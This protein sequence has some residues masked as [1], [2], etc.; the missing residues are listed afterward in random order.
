VVR[1]ALPPI[2]ELRSVG[3]VLAA[4]EEHRNRYR[5]LQLAESWLA[6]GQIVRHD[7]LEQQQLRRC[8]IVLEE[9][10]AHT[11]EAARTL[12][13]CHLP[14]AALG[15]AQLQRVADNALWRPSA[16]LWS[17]LAA[18]GVEVVA[19]FTPAQL[20]ET[21]AAFAK[22]RSPAPALHQALAAEATRRLLGAEGTGGASGE[23]SPEQISTMAWA[24]ASAGH[25]DPAL[26]DAIATQA[27]RRASDFTPRELANLAWAYATA[28]LRGSVKTSLVE[29]PAPAL[30]D[31]R[32]DPNPGTSLTAPALLDAVAAEAARRVDEFQP[33]EL[34]VLIWAVAA[35]RH[36]APQL[37]RAAAPMVTAR[38]RD[39]DTHALIAMAWAYATAEHDAP[40]KGQYEAMHDELA[41][42]ATRRLSGRRGSVSKLSPQQLSTM[43]SALRSPELTRPLELRVEALEEPTLSE[44]GGPRDKPAT[45]AGVLAA[46][47][48]RGD[49]AAPDLVSLHA[50]LLKWLGL[51]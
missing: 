44:R 43:R 22:A 5:P 12:Q 34:V 1:S 3:E 21:A 15:M 6:L 38:A 23:L 4:H 31:A 2:D 28:E 33:H 27:A 30:L 41:A 16:A 13:P 14:R 19:E 11:V 24:H 17:S 29:R 51:F 35:Y 37:L 10:T 36:P 48:A 18:R 26:L 45:G 49:A 7:E 8:P 46:E 20:V 25:A 42:A 9:L 50:R 40:T 39:L 47:A 32:P